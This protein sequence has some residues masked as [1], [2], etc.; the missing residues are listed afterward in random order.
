MVLYFYIYI[1][2]GGV[3]WLDGGDGD[4]HCYYYIGS[5]KLKEADVESGGVGVGFV[6]VC[7]LRK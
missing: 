5:K 7:T 3:W 1:Y 6:Y 4:G 2:E